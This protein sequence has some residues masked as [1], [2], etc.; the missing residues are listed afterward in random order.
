MV[1]EVVPEAFNSHLQG[2]EMDLEAVAMEV[3]TSPLVSM[4]LEVVPEAISH[5][6]EMDLEAVAMEAIIRLL[7]VL[8]VVPEAINRLQEMGT[9]LEELAMEEISALQV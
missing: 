5:L 6:R 4:V 9:S 1:L 2:M 3:I 7:V 8:E